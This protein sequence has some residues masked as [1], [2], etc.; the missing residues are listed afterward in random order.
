[1][2]IV[3]VFFFFSSR[4]RHTRYWRDWSSD[5]CSSDLGQPGLLPGAGQRD[6][7]RPP[8]RGHVRSARDR[9]LRGQGR[10]GAAMTGPSP[11][12]EAED[13]D[14]FY[15]HAQALHGVSFAV[16]DGETVALIGAN[17]AGKST[18]LSTVAGAMHPARG[19]IRWEGRDITRVPDHKR[20]ALGI[21]LTPEGRRL[22]PSLTVAENLQ[23][24]AVS[25]R[26]G[27]W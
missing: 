20:V 15:G 13:L 4:R 23:V 11:L 19:S 21:S 7:R 9:G 12:I 16:G 27:E 6:R 14:V 24:G 17:G 10:E 1:M 25:K 3:I 5:V 8:A 22:F 18:L 26:A 2:F